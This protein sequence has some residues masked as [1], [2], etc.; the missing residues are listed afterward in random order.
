M[1]HYISGKETL[2][3]AVF[4]GIEDRIRFIIAD[5]SSGLEAVYPRLASGIRRITE[6][7]E[8]SLQ[9]AEKIIGAKNPAAILGR[10]YSITYKDGHI[11][12][13]VSAAEPGDRIRIRLADGDIFAVVEKTERN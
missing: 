6:E 3:S 12:D 2:S 8:R 7:K 9:S 1:K 13:S 10:G 4:P 5:I 11:V